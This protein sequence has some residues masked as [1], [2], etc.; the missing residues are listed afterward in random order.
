M[1]STKWKWLVVIGLVAGLNDMVWD[2]E[3]A[4]CEQFFDLIAFFLLFLSLSF[5]VYVCVC[6]YDN[7]EGEGHSFHTNEKKKKTSTK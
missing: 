5:C 7:N 6:W 2:P 3:K 4:I 1:L